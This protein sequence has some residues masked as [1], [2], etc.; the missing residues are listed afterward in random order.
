MVLTREDLGLLK[1]L[2]AA[3]ECGRTIRA[4]DARIVLNRLAKGGLVHARPTGIELVNYRIAQ[5]G[6][7]AIVEHDLSYSPSTTASPP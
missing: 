6:K 2:A 4:F 1:Q 5:R 7:D 3:G